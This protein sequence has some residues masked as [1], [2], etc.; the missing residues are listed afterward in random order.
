[1]QFLQFLFCIDEKT[2]ESWARIVLCELK[3]SHTRLRVAHFFWFTFSS[4]LYFLLK[5][6][7]RLGTAAMKRAVL[8]IEAPLRSDYGTIDR[9]WRTATRQP[10]V[11]S[12][13][14]SI[15]ALEQHRQ[16]RQH[17]SRVWWSVQG[18]PRP[19]TNAIISAR[20]NE[21]SLMLVKRGRVCVRWV[22][23]QT[24]QA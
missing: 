9:R 22:Q 12:G 10:A 8:P 24:P 13:I 21:K 7:L 3:D 20:K 17:D 6:N 19:T 2:S 1:M 15:V 14:N 4:S 11:T 5:I 18:D 16:R 23:E